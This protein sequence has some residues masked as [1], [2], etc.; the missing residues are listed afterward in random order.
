MEA[1]GGKE[2]D[3]RGNRSENKRAMGASAFDPRG[4]SGVC[5]LPRTVDFATFRDSKSL[6]DALV[7]WYDRMRE[8]ARLVGQYGGRVA[9]IASA[10]RRF[11][12]KH[13][14]II[15]AYIS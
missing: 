13:K 7:A 15:L 11:I 12:P 3:C 6:E 14:G 5:R 1:A 8:C 4:I 2:T 10:L 9:A